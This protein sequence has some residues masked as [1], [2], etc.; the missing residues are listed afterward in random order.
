MIGW[1]AGGVS[2]VLGD[3]GAECNRPRNSVTRRCGAFDGNKPRRSGE[4]ESSRRSDE[5]SSKIFF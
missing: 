3:M 1:A 4:K 5:T 2:K